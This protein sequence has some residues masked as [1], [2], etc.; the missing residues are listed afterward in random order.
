MSVGSFGN[1]QLSSVNY[2]NVDILY[3]YSATR[4]DVGDLQFTPLF[5]N[6]TN[7]ELR[8]II[9]AGGGLYK[10]RLPANVFNKLGFYSVLIKPKSF[11]VEIID[12]SFIVQN[13]DNEIQ[14]S[15][16]GIVIPTLQFRQTGS[17]IGYQVQ[18]FDDN[19]VQIDNLSRII[20]SSDLVS[21]A[22]NTNSS[23]PA[24][25]SYN[26]DPNGSFLFLTLTP[27][28]LS[29]LSSQQKVDLGKAGQKILLSN[30]FFDPEIIEIEMVDQTIKTLGY[31]LYG[32]STRDLDSGVF[33]VFDEFGNL[34]RQ[35][36]LFVAKKAFNDGQIDIKQNRTSINL[37]QTF[38]NLAQGIGS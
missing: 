30:T 38:F 13:Q 8:K 27:D 24:S 14:I 26:L 32:N 20:T 25:T 3:T 18:Y 11:E 2:N 35:Y 21:L 37:D 33:S 19:G 7:N 36:N 12:C 15:K 28:E 16:K 22:S 4:Q 9:G 10:L 1:R 34:Y 29:L 6:I 5:N 17:L 23:S 31:A